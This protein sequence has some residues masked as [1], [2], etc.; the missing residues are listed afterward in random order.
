[1]LWTEIPV[2][3]IDFEGSRETGV[4]EFGVVT[5]LGGAITDVATRLCRPRARLHADDTRVHGLRDG[6]LAGAAPFADEWERFA[7]LRASGVLAAHFSGTENAL[8]RAT[9]PCP[10]LSPDFLHPGHSSA[11]W[12]PWIDTGRIAA[13]ARMHAGGATFSAAL[14][15]LVRALALDTILD[16][17]AARACPV[18]RRSFHCALYDALACAFVLRRLAC[19][20]DGAPWTLARTL[21]A[22]TGD[23]DQRDALVQ[24]RLF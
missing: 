1:V 12:G 24:G 8:L 14:G 10:R 3:V 2:H 5:L 6:D 17:A 19:E 21:A 20:H 4:V 23:G 11:E 22:S 7:A 18:G 9:W 13:A 15:D 16:D